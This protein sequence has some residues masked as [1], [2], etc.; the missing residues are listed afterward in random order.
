MALPFDLELCTWPDKSALVRF[1]LDDDIDRWSRKAEREVEAHEKRKKKGRLPFEFRTD[2]R[3]FLVSPVGSID[4]ALQIDTHGDDRERGVVIDRVAPSWESL[5]E[6]AVSMKLWGLYL[7]LRDIPSVAS[8]LTY[9]GQEDVFLEFLLPDLV[10]LK[11]RP[12]EEDYQAIWPVVSWVNEIFRF[13]SATG[14]SSPF[15][16][17]LNAAEHLRQGGID[18]LR[19][20][21]FEIQ[22]RQREKDEA[23]FSGWKWSVYNFVVDCRSLDKDDL[24]EALFDAGVCFW[25]EED[26][27]SFIRKQAEMPV[28]PEP[29]QLELLLG[30]L[31]SWLYL[32]TKELREA[33]GHGP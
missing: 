10:D 12:G 26:A 7:Y 14:S 31:P 6:A 28:F 15:C 21:R 3:F 8:R 32:S 11:K 2:M 13:G 20:K 17:A 19:T 27:L 29:V 25:R 16:Q 1:L 30:L 23:G 4:A 33:M 9:L 5:P 24:D 22:R 18:R